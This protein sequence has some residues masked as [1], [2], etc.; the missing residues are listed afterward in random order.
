MGNLKDNPVQREQPRSP[1]S[2]DVLAS[3]E[4]VRHS[5]LYNIEHDSDVIEQE[6]FI[7]KGTMLPFCQDCGNP[8]KY[9]LIQKME[10][11][12]EDPDFS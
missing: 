5:G 3:G 8:I 6:I 7:R 12:A 1:A 10:Y 9:R 4:N 2:N 11:I